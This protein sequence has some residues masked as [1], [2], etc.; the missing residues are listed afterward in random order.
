[1]RGGPANKK[2]STGVLSCSTVL[3]F[4]S[5]GATPMCTVFRF[6]YNK[7]SSSSLGTRA[8]VIA[9]RVSVATRRDSPR[10]VRLAGHSFL[11]DFCAFDAQFCARVR[12]ALYSRKNHHASL[13]RTDDCACVWP[14]DPDIHGHVVHKM[15]EATGI[16]R[17]VPQLYGFPH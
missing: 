9:P 7:L 13:N 17:N 8:S 14:R 2:C 4:P 5:P 6:V 12:S 3:Y 15:R 11:R 1:M 16:Q 10:L